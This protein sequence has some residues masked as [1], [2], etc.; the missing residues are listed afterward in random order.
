MR[1]IETLNGVYLMGFFL[2]ILF[3]TLTKAKMPLKDLHMSNILSL[4]RKVKPFMLKSFI[5]TSSRQV[6]LFEEVR[7][8][9]YSFYR[10]KFNK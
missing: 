7:K 4:Y 5:A 3:Y 10:N 8:S 9:A 1:N 6:F 2:T